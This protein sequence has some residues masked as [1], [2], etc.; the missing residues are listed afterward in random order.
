MISTYEKLSAAEKKAI[1][2]H[3]FDIFQMYKKLRTPGL[4]ALTCG[5]EVHIVLPNQ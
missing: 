1:D 4:T 3:G 2:P 5:V